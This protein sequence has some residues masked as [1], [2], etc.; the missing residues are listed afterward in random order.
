M[1]LRIDFSR[2]GWI[3]EANL[4]R[5]I[6]PNRSDKRGMAWRGLMTRRG[7]AW[8]GEARR[9]V[10]WQ[11]VKGLKRGLVRTWSSG[12]KGLAL[13]KGVDLPTAPDLKCRG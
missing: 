3:L 2:F 5:K 9:G 10:A 4:G 11:G 6:H 1:P 13:L 8:R 7:E 12:T